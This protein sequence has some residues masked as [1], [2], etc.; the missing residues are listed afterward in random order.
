MHINT[1]VNVKAYAC[2]DN[3]YL[4]NKYTFMIRTITTA[5]GHPYIG[6]YIVATVV[7][8]L[9]KSK[10]CKLYVVSGR[11]SVQSTTE[12]LLYIINAF[13]RSRK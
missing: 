3:I 4:E 8:C 10:G 7:I 6:N 9:N 11:T 2:Q 13:G 12:C 1:Y 5:N